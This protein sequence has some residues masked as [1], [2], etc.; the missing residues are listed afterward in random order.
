MFNTQSTGAS[1]LKY[2]TAAKLGLLAAALAGITAGYYLT[3]NYTGSAKVPLV[4][5]VGDQAI[6]RAELD[7]L[8]A[9]GM[10]PAIARDAVIQRAVLAMAADKEFPADADAALGA[11]VRDAKAQVFLAKKAD[12]LAR[13]ITEEDL[14]AW[15]AQN[16]RAEDYQQLKVRF[17]HSANLEDAREVAQAA[18]A[19]DRAAIAKYSSLSKATDG[20]APVNDVPYDL[21]RA[22]GQQKQGVYGEPV[23]VRTGALSLVLDD[24]RA[25][26]KPTLEAIKDQIRQILVRTRLA[27]SI[28]RLRSELKIELRG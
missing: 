8:L 15:Y 20:F 16:I 18:N 21:G 23:M 1:P 17:Y 22:V 25:K 2:R 26:E 10:D 28:G 3:G 5:V 9:T 14:A 6:P 27:E 4:A 11:V 7:S 24:K 19:G 13:A 12:S